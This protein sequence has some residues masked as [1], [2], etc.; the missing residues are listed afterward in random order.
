MIGTISKQRLTRTYSTISAPRPR[1]YPYAHSIRVSSRD[2]TATGPSIRHS[3]A[4]SSIL[5][6][7]P[8][9]AFFLIKNLDTGKEFIVKEYDEDGM[10]NRLS[11]LQTGKQLTMEEFEKCVGYSPVVKELMRRENVSRISGA[12]GGSHRKATSSNSYITR[13]LRMSKRRGVALLKNSIKGVANSM[14][15]F[16]CEKEREAQPPPLPPAGTAEQK[17]GRNSNSTSSGWIKVRPSG[18][19]YKE[20]TALHLCQEIQAHEGSIWCIKFNMEGRFLA[21]AGEDRIV[22]VWEVQECEVMSLREEGNGTT[23]LHPSICPSP[24]RPQSLADVPVMPLEKKKKG[25]GAS[26]RRGGNSVIPDYVHVPETVFALSD[27]PICSF[28]GHLDDVLDLSWSRNQVRKV[29]VYKFLCCY[30]LFDPIL[31]SIF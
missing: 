7:S 8:F 5:S 2:Q 22:Q 27:K 4:L 10:W 17:A 3:G 18:K 24:D 15:G 21:S 25:K 19:A 1:I 9:G 31:T 26:S 12:E 23:P 13:S 6:T 28:Q 20:L 14:S 29:S 30:F 11:D 16:I